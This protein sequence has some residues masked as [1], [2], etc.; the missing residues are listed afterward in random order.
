MPTSVPVVTAFNSLYSSVLKWT[1]VFILFYAEDNRR[2][3]LPNVCTHQPNWEVSHPRRPYLYAAPVHNAA[4][5]G[6]HDSKFISLSDFSLRC[7][8]CR[9]LWISLSAPHWQPGGLVEGETGLF[10]LKT[11]GIVDILNFSWILS[12]GWGCI[13]WELLSMISADVSKWE[14]EVNKID[15]KSVV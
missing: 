5:S 1:A 9:C 4:C 15:R 11:G 7:S 10:L 14:R 8:A 2:R 3:F 6:S 12:R 13:Q